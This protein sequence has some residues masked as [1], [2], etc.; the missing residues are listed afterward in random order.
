MLSPEPSE[1]PLDL[2]VTHSISVNLDL[3]TEKR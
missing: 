1:F 2:F 3:K